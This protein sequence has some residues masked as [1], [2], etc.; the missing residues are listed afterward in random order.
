MDERWGLAF[1][2]LPRLSALPSAHSN[3][4]HSVRSPL[5]DIK[6]HCAGALCWGTDGSSTPLPWGCLWRFPSCSGQVL[7]VPP[8]CVL[9]VCALLAPP[10]AKPGIGYRLQGTAHCM[11]GAQ[12]GGSAW[13]SGLVPGAE[14][15]WSPGKPQTLGRC[16]TAEQLHVECEALCCMHAEPWW[17]VPGKECCTQPA[18]VAA[19]WL[20]PHHGHGSGLHNIGLAKQA[21]RPGKSSCCCHCSE[22]LNFLV[23]L[24][25]LMILFGGGGEGMHCTVKRKGHLMAFNPCL[26][27]G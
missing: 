24:V 15:G 20:R 10:A 12:Q 21:G 14:T 16:S 25:D 26:L 2:G 22:L 11:G 27:L 5:A 18:V 9:E 19:S 4:L 23:G 7:D 3:S 17:K 13:G 8:C 1:S 6:G